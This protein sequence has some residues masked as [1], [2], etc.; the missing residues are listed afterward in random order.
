MM[1]ALPDASGPSQRQSHAE[2]GGAFGKDCVGEQRSESATAIVD[3]V[4][5]CLE[6]RAP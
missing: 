4:G 3:D 6:W 5:G 1:P 2:G